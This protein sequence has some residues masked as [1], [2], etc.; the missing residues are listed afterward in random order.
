MSLLTKKIGIILLLCVLGY[1]LHRPFFDFSTILFS[2]D[3]TNRSDNAV[4]DLL[5]KW[6][7]SWQSHEWFGQ[8]F[9]QS[10]FFWFKVLWWLIGKYH[11]ATKLTFLIPIA[12]LSFISPFILSCYL[13]KNNL[14]VA[15][16]S[17]IFY[18]T[19]TYLSV[20]T[21][22][23]LPIAMVFVLAPLILT[24]FLRYL[25]QQ[26]L[27][28]LVLF[29]IVYFIGIVYEIRIMSIVSLILLVTL[30][31]LAKKSDRKKI[32]SWVAATFLIQLLLNAYRLLP[33]MHLSWGT[34]SETIN[35]WL[36]GGH[37]FNISY[38]MTLFDSSRTWSMPNQAFVPQPIPRYMWFYPC[39]VVI[40]FLTTSGKS[41]H[42]FLRWC[43][44][45]L[46]WALL[47][48]QSAMPIPWLYQWLYDHIPGFNLF[49]EASKFYQITAIGYLIM[50]SIVR[51]SLRRKQRWATCLLLL[52]SLCISGLLAVPLVNW[53]IWLLRSPKTIPAEYTAYNN[54][55]DSSTWAYK[56]LWFPDDSQRSTYSI[57]HPKVS[58]SYLTK[59]EWR[60]LSKSGTWIYTH[61]MI[62]LITDEM[63]DRGNIQYLV[64]PLEDVIKQQFG[65]ATNRIQ[66]ALANLPFIQPVEHT[67]FW[68]LKVYINTGAYGEVFW[69]PITGNYTP[70]SREKKKSSEITFSC[71]F[72][73]SV[74]FLSQQYNKQRQLYT[75]TPHRREILFWS[76]APL[77]LPEKEYDGIMK[78]TYPV[79]ANKVYTLY[80]LPEAWFML[81]IYLHIIGVFLCILMYVYVYPPQI[82]QKNLHSI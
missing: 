39:M 62:P 74:L 18:G 33:V 23:H 29:N 53:S 31:F 42:L 17:S 80:F 9:V 44:L 82:N 5:F 37:L 47:T 59:R 45:F 15:T 75:W 61:H 11:I 81:G 56:H 63:L 24:T 26:S 36:F 2:S 13:T 55:I 49:R 6:L 68:S 4:K 8:E 69:T 72:S 57:Q 60:D 25:D 76:V 7:M 77:A 12:L 51:D 14:L 21:T 46:V 16:V 67:A 73:P 52:C 38:A 58:F 79:Q 19:I 30:F 66:K 71:S 50:L 43:G 65:T 28:T 70:C 54:L 10:S 78:F 40:G 22:A 27:R 20:K 64:I 32:A 35:R 48:K 3:W 41:R 34:I 1:V